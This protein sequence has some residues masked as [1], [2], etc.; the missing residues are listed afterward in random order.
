[1]IQ[2]A[3]DVIIDYEWHGDE[4][5]ARAER[6]IARGTIAIGETVASHGKR[7]VHVISGDLRRSIHTAKSGTGGMVRA[8][9]QAV[10]TR[11]GAML[12]VGSWLDYACVEEVGRGHAYMTP[13]MEQSRGTAWLSMRAAFAA[14]GLV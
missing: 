14:E 1:M 7:N 6:A 3:T 8:S 4:I 9:V 10:K 12:D 5:K 13:A 2:M 11:D